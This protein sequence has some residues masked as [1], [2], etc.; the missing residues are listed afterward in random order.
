MRASINGGVYIE[1]TRTLLKDFPP[2]LEVEMRI[3]DS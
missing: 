1:Q 3:G 2:A